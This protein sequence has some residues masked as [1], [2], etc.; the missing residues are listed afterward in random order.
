MLQNLISAAALAS[1]AQDFGQEDDI[2][3][4]RIQREPRSEG[5]FDAITTVAA[6]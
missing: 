5:V 4:L 3:A 1:A 6:T 2:L